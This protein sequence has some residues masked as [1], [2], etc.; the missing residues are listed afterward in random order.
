MS[1]GIDISDRVKYIELTLGAF[2]SF[3]IDLRYMNNLF[4][5]GITESIDYTNIA[6]TDGKPNVIEGP[7]VYY[8]CT[9]LALGFFKE[10]DLE[11]TNRYGSL[12]EQIKTN[13]ISS[14]CLLNKNKQPIKAPI[15]P[16]GEKTI[17]TNEKFGTLSV[18]VLNREK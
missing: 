5:D 2:P 12:F 7:E 3:I 15:H 1:M 17:K 14:I 6:Y 16:H 9:F 13:D 11:Y 8:E 4:I 18:Q 10:A